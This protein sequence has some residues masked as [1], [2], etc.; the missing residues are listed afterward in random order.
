MCRWQVNLCDPS[1]TCHSQRFRFGL[2]RCAIQINVYFT[3]LTVANDCPTACAHWLSTNKCLLIKYSYTNLGSL[4]K[5]SLI[6]ITGFTRGREAVRHAFLHQLSSDHRAS[7]SIIHMKHWKLN[8]SE[9]FCLS[10]DF[11]KNTVNNEQYS[12]HNQTRTSSY[13]L[14]TNLL[15]ISTMQETLYTNTRNKNE[16]LRYLCTKFLQEFDY[17]RIS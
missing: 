3:F 9:F 1:N 8:S 4:R 15:I 16:S 10:T 11:V 7:V 12:R 6:F 2:R 13:G 14:P 5:R 17:E